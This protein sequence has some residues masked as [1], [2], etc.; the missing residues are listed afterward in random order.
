MLKSLL[1]LCVLVSISL[2]TT[3]RED[4]EITDLPGLTFDVNFSQYSGYITLDQTTKNIFYWFVESQNNPTTDP[5]ILWLQGGPGCSDFG[6]GTFE[7]NGPYLPLVVDYENQLVNLTFNP[8]S[9]N[10]V[11][12]V[13]YIDSPCG[14]GFSYGEV[15]S[16]TQNT[17]NGTAIDTYVFLQQFF[18]IYS[19]FATNDF[20]ITGE[21]YAGVYITNLA[22]EILTNTSSPQLA[23][24]LKNGGIQLGNPVTNCAGAEYNGEG[25]V[26][27]LDLQVNLFYWHGMVSRRNF[28]NWNS[29]GCNTQTPPSLSAC[30]TLYTTIEKGIGR[31]D[32]PL[33]ARNRLQPSGSIN[34]DMLYFSYCTGN[35]TIDFVNAINPGCFSVDDQVSVYLNTA[36]VQTAIHAQPTNWEECGGVEYRSSGDSVI[37]HLQYFFENA[38]TMKVWYYSGD[39]DIATVPFAQTQRCLATLNAKITEAW[40]PYTINKEVAGYVEVYDTYTY[41]TIKGAGHEAPEFQPAAGFLVFTSMLAGTPPPRK[42]G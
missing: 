4:A 17:D 9:W 32:Q 26:L 42:S 8:Y 12:S 25:N 23:T 14:V 38:P 20:Y 41:L 22:F 34:P 2:A 3:S 24:N 30:I 28:D 13:I 7:E 11:A 36:A 16:D 18:E 33:K 6:G 1:L 35:G 37:P 39:L 15:K 27:D 29:Q 5:V 40:R 10:R 21:S 19:E 31:L